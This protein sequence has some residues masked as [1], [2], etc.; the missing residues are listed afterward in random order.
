MAG[1]LS[2]LRVVDF[3]RVLAGPFGTR[4]LADHGAEVIKVQSEVTAAGP[5]HNIS[6]YFNTWNRNKL[7]ITLN[8]SRPEA[9]ELAKKLVEISDVVVENFSPRVMKNWGLDY[10]VLKGIKRDLIMLSMSAMGQTGPWQDYVGFGAT[11]QAFSGIT[12]LTGFPGQPPAGVGYS[13]ADHVGGLMGVLA[14]LQAVEHRQRTGEGQHIDL[15]E[16]EATCSLLGTALL[17][18]RC[19]GRDA[20]PAGNSPVHRIAA[21]HGV[22]RCRGEDRW[23]A[24]AVFT[25]EEWQA[26]CAVL[27]RPSW[28]TEARFGSQLDRW[29]NA[30]ELDAAVGEWTQEH[31]AEEVMGLLQSAGI[32]AGL[33]QNGADLAQDPQ[34]RAR[35][36][37]VELEHPVM[38]MTVSDGSPVR[39]SDMPAVYSR[40]APTL[41]QDNDYVYRCLLGIP[42]E[43]MERYVADGVIL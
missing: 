21:P 7:G 14:V 18:L 38:G 4:M 40:A 32:A 8:L 34:L 41:G 13:Y 5:Q 2:D 36:F 31:N 19:N 11:V 3:S 43:D 22:Y 9:I 28:T 15:S 26:F 42:E 17:D 6:G 29:R 30:G 24:I 25:E 37:F 16:T 10:T 33:V 23:C 35:G 12:Y 39:L 20:L 27:G 1:A